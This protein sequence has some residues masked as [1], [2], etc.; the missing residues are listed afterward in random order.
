MKGK[1][2]LLLAVA[3]GCGLVAM[4]GVQKALKKD[5]NASEM[6]NV[7]VATS[8]I[9]SG[10]PLD[11]SN[12]RFEQFPVTNVPEGAVTRP[13]EYEERALIGNA[14]TGEIIMLAKLGEKGVIGAS[15]EI[16]NG[17]RVVSVPVD[18]TSTHSG[19]IA[20]EDRVDLLVTYKYHDPETR[21]Y[22]SKTRTILEYVKVFSVDNKRERAGDGTEVV[23]KNVSLL[24]TPE[25][26]HLVMLAKDKG[27]LQL[28]LRSKTDT[29]EA[30]VGAIDEKVFEEWSPGY[31][32]HH[33][34]M[35]EEINEERKRA[36]IAQQEAIRQALLQERAGQQAGNQPEPQVAVVEDEPVQQ[37]EIPKWEIVIFAGDQKHVEE[38]ELPTQEV[39]V[40][41]ATQQPT[42]ADP[43]TWKGWLQ[44]L[45]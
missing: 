23:A 20:P 7:L 28:A 11:D 10:M 21:E 32:H 43:A 39:S 34:S 33:D 17:M 27:K 15:A 24:V 13:E 41:K 30:N 36:A 19:Q 29:E 16:P 45:L 37:P 2:I 9:P 35:E 22:L 18:A 44:N 4:L 5:P 26:A 3:M 38:L 40:D 31:S 42:P 12:T 14:V 1:T 25:D 8:E 6:V